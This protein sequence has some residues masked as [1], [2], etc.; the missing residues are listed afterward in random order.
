[1]TPRALGLTLSLG[2]GDGGSQRFTCLSR[3]NS[4]HDPRVCHGDEDKNWV[5]SRWKVEI[6]YRLDKNIP[7]LIFPIFKECLV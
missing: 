3:F 2:A 7:I 4:A 6:I 5:E 1:M